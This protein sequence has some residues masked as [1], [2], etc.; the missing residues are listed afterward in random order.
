[1]LKPSFFPLFFP[2]PPVELGPFESK[3]F[4]LSEVGIVP[5]TSPPPNYFQVHTYWDAK[6]PTVG[7][8]SWSA[9]IVF[10]AFG[11]VARS[12]EEGFDLPDRGDR[13]D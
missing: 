10:N 8:K 11:F 6:Q 1:M 9:T 5:V 3:G 12:S 4:L 13:D 2:A 7:L